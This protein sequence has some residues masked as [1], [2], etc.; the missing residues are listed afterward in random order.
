MLLKTSVGVGMA[1]S[2]VGRR[3]R[4]EVL[5]LVLF[6]DECTS[7]VAVTCGFSPLGT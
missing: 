6:D 5:R 3:R 7:A 1:I 2:R 4:E